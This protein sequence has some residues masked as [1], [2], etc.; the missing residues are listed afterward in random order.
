V[1]YA[2][3]RLQLRLRL[4]SIAYCSRTID[5]F[6]GQEDLD[7]ILTMVAHVPAAMKDADITRFAHRAAQLESVKPVIA[8][9]CLFFY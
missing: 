7:T 3:L 8:Y 1:A 5:V 4:Q 9:W 2:K 6:C